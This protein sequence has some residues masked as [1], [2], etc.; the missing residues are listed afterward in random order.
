MPSSFN[1][2]FQNLCPLC[3]GPRV[4][5][6]FSHDGNRNHLL[7]GP[8][9]QFLKKGP[10]PPQD[11]VGSLQGLGLQ[12]A[13]PWAASWLWVNSFFPRILGFVPLL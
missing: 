11:G 9:E 7:P 5:P 10:P 8:S 4:S 12:M 13:V 6:S 1:M 2:G 3:K